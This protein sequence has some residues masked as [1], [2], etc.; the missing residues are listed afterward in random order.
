ML[1]IT[2]LILT[3]KEVTPEFSLICAL[4]REIQS[5]IC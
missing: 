5:K 3:L 2:K 1:G 4:V